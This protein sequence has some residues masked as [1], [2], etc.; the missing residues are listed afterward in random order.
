MMIGNKAKA[1][2]FGVRRVRKTVFVRLRRKKK[3]KNPPSGSAFQPFSLDYMTY[4]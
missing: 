3:K 1:T 2:N 4:E